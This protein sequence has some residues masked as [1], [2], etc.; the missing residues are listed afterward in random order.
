MLKE[1][2]EEF[3]LVKKILEDNIVNAHCGIFDTRNIAGDEMFNIFNGKYFTVD[4]CYFYSYY[5]VF[6]THKNEFKEL[7][8]YYNKLVE[9]E[10][11]RIYE[12]LFCYITGSLNNQICVKF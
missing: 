8:K 11:E 3:E 2:R 6:G 12:E 7:E 4:I 5:E 9:R 10:S 1:R